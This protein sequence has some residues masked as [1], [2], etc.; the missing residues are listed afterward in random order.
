MGTLFLLE[1]IFFVA[2]L[3]DVAWDIL[4]ELWWN[5]SVRRDERLNFMKRKRPKRIHWKFR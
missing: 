3:G 1:A 2:V 4:S 5:V